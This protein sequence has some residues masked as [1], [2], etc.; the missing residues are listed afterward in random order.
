MRHSE[1]RQN[2]CITQ[3]EETAC[4]D[5]LRDDWELMLRE[6]CHRMQNTLALLGA[7]VRRDFAKRESHTEAVARFER[8][9]AAF[10]RLYELL[11]TDGE[12]DLIPLKEF[13]DDLSR[14]W[15][16]AILEPAGID[17]EVAIESG[18]LPAVECRRLGLIIQ[19]CLVLKLSWA[20]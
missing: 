12:C 20:F 17:C 13:L 16:Q 4:A 1:L 6:N 10:G 15:T 7:I 18:A 19:G 5:K 8:R 14:A 11:S 2:Y 9:L 3:S